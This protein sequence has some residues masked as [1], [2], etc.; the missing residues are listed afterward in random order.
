MAGWSWREKGWNTGDEIWGNDIDKLLRPGTKGTD[1]W[2][3][4][5]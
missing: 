3:P 5:I 4:N 2:V 1:I